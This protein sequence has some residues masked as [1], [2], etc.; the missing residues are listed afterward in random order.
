MSSMLRE[1]NHKIMT[2]RL[3]IRVQTFLS[4]KNEKVIGQALKNHLKIA[5]SH[6][7]FYYAILIASPHVHI[8]LQTFI[9]S[10][11]ALNSRNPFKF[12]FKV[13]NTYGQTFLLI[14]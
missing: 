4:P 10:C 14:H 3:H 2:L 13:G 9:H 5:V 1:K 6:L 8:T 7:N 12:N 11:L